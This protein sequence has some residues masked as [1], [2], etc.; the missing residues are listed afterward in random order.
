MLACPARCWTYF[1]CEPRESK[2]VAQVCLRLWKRISGRPA[3]FSKGLK[4]MLTM[5][6]VSSSVPMVS[7][8]TGSVSADTDQGSAAQAG[9]RG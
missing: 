6:W 1:G 5:F 4:C 3:Y 2:R 8:V 7:G 9:L